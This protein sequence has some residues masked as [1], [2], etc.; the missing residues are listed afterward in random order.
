MIVE[1]LH[2]VLEA[3][4]EGVVAVRGGVCLLDIGGER[5]VVRPQHVLQVRVPELL[6]G[7]EILE[8]RVRR[9]FNNLDPDPLPV[10]QGLETPSSLQFCRLVGRYCSCLLPGQTNSRNFQDHIM[11]NLATEVMDDDV[12]GS[13]YTRLN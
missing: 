6:V 7:V 9:C 1:V 5:V 11:Q 3:V 8:G 10:S 12:N 4:L 13:I 2:E